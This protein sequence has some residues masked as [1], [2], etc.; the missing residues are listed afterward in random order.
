MV[1]T[2]EVSVDDATTV[3]QMVAALLA[4]LG[5]G[6]AQ[7][8][9]DTQLVADLLAMTERVSGFLAF[10]E[11][12]PVGI[13]MLSESASLF[14]R[15]TYGIITE[16]YV[17]PDQRSSGVAMRLIE[18]AVGLGTKKGWGQLEVGAPNQPM[19]SRSPNSALYL[20]AGF[21]EI[22]P[23]L[24]LPLHGLARPRVQ[25]SPAAAPSRLDPRRRRASPPY[26][27][28]IHCKICMSVDLWGL[29]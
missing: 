27:G 29:T 5:A 12:R 24:K 22:G 18:A 17:V 2:R 3:T 7:A 13:I 20:K 28:F 1:T 26:P 6:H 9:L 19:W 8:G 15:G 16:L 25:S 11:E 10:T 23:R 14:A 4:E 21:A